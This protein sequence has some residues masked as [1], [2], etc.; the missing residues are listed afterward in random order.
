MRA[1]PSVR[2]ISGEAAFPVA[3]PDRRAAPRRTPR[4]R[5]ARRGRPLH[6]WLL[7]IGL[8]ALSLGLHAAL[9]TWLITL[10]APPAPRHPPPTA[11]TLILLTPPA[12]VPAP[13]PPPK[14][15][16]HR[17]HHPAPVSRPAP[18]PS[19]L[20]PP[21]PATAT[22]A[23]TTAPPPESAIPDSAVP[24]TAPSP[25]AAAAAPV[26]AAPPPD[27][28]AAYA[29][30]VWARLLSHRP[31]GLAATGTVIIRVSVAADGAVLTAAVAT[32][33]GS[34]LLD[35]IA[36]DAVRTASPLPVP[37]AGLLTAPGGG[38]TF[39]VPFRFH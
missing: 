14:P 16:D 31:A 26:A 32:S 19:P 6:A 9:L 37:P 29:R 22:A 39:T 28:L 23:L 30:A 27:L 25:S 38:L 33:S 20:S 24:A 8:A 1:V 10:P 36:L 35:G 15:A 18:Q 3:A 12:A 7:R 2:R 13:A 34:D 4:W 5:A 17:A 11:T 21:V